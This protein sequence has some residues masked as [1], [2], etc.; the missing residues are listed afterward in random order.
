MRA[1]YML[2]ALPNADEPFNCDC[3]NLIRCGDLVGFESLA[4]MYTKEYAISKSEFLISIILKQIHW[5][6]K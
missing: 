3:G 4:E 2:L 1:I 5:H 6:L